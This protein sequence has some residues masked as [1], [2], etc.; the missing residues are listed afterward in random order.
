[1]IRRRE[2]ITLLGGAAAAWPVRARAQPAA[3]PLAGFLTNRSP[4]E[5]AHLVAA[6]RQGLSE[7]GHVEGKN[8]Q[9]DFRFAEGQFDRL[10]GLA[11]QLVPA[12]S[13][14]R[15]QPQRSLSFSYL[16]A[17]RSRPASSPA[18]TGRAGTSPE[19]AGSALSWVPNGWNCCTNWF[20]M[21]RSSPC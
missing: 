9:I 12:R 8:I 6:F 15:P 3:T 2:L 5:S 17:I 1:M 19:W 20:P 21:L 18:S 11:W 4:A 14:S 16:A 13:R 10:P 7:T